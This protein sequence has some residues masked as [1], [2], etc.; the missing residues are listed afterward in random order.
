MI[1]STFAAVDYANIVSKRWPDLLMR[2][3]SHLA[4]PNGA[5]GQRVT[6]RAERLRKYSICMRSADLLD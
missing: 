5:E 3:V 2:K 4:W 6:V 1:G